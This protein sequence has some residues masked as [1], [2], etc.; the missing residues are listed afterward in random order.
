MALC[1]FLHGRHSVFSSKGGGGQN[2]RGTDQSVGNCLP[3]KGCLSMP[4]SREL[5]RGAAAAFVPCSI[6]SS[7]DDMQYRVPVPVEVGPGGGR[8]RASSQQHDWN[9]RA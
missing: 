9:N 8:Q 5:G 2:G 7:R 6:V 1:G 4:A 3:P